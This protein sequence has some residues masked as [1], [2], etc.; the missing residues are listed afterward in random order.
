MIIMMNTVIRMVVIKII[1][2]MGCSTESRQMVY[3]TNVVFVCQFFNTGVLPMLCTAN[4]NH[5]LPTWIVNMFGFNGPISDFNIDWFTNIG[6]T[7]VGSLKFNIYFQ[8]CME[9]GWFSIRLVKRL[10]DRTGDEDK[11][12]KSGSIY[13]Y[14]NKFAGPQYFM[15]YKYSSIM[16][17]IYLTMMFG[18]AMPI[19]F[20]ICFATLLVQYTLEI[21]MLHYVFK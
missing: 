7:I 14:V 1:T 13:Q 15:H 12:T 16:N 20:P 10:L 19:L 4:L 17:V 5:Q 3:I 21:S 11:P 8:V 2:Y 9:C 6:D 18:P